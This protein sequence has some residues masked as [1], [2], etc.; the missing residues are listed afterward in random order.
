MAIEDV[1]PEQILKETRDHVLAH[2]A[3]KLIEAGYRIVREKEEA[4][5]IAFQPD[6]SAESS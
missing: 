5:G 2:Q 6:H 4:D 1:T 3:R